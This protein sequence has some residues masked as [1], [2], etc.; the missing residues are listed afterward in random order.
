[1]V[2]A[3]GSVAAI[4][5]LDNHQDQESAAPSRTRSQRPNWKVEEGNRQHATNRD[6]AAVSSEKQ[7]KKKATGNARRDG[8]E[9][10]ARNNCPN[11]KTGHRLRSAFD[12]SEHRTQDYC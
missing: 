11:L 12:R 7:A 1:M 2:I 6:E 8:R 3:P 5:P 9:N 4:E 10:H